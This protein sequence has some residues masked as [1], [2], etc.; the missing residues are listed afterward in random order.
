MPL[1][2]GSSKE[3]ISKNIATEMA[4]GK[5]QKQAVAIAMREAG[6]PKAKDAA[7]HDPKSGQ[8]TS[9][10]GGGKNET[11]TAKQSEK[12]YHVYSN[13]PQRG[14]VRIS[15]KPMTEKEA[16]QF[17]AGFNRMGAPGAYRTEQPYTHE[18][19]DDAQPAAVTQA[20]SGMPVYKDRNLDAEPCH[21]A[22]I[23][24]PVGCDWPGRV[25]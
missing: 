17:A 7:A 3:T 4:H 18:P 1:E 8:F 20:S 25:L 11:T 10:N 19:I 2:K 5:P 22:G 15:H 16:A 21:D 6:V 12:M 14:K 9:G 23:S 24:S 13:S